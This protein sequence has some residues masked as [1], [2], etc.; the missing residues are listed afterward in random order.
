M[1]WSL[2]WVVLATSLE[3]I[4]IMGHSFLALLALVGFLV[5]AGLLH[6][7]LLGEELVEGCRRGDGALVLKREVGGLLLQVLAAR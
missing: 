6:G 7:L 4:V 1:R 2:L 3:H 5:D